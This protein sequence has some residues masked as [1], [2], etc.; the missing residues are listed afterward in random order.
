MLLSYGILYIE[1]RG[2]HPLMEKLL[3]D[4]RIHP[5][6]PMQSGGDI[7]GS[8]W[9]TRRLYDS[10]FLNSGIHSGGIQYTSLEFLYIADSHFVHGMIGMVLLHA[11]PSMETVFVDGAVSYR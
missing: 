10:D 9:K 11:G 5:T 4:D 2:V 7:A 3:I 1:P 6:I 8:L